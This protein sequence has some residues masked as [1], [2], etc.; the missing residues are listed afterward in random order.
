MIHKVKGL[1]LINE[2]EVLI[3]VS[4]VIPLLSP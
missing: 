1:R 2:S 3:G 4:S